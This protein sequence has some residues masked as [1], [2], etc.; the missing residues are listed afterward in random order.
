[1]SS[2][3][4]VND[5]VNVTASQIMGLKLVNVNVQTGFIGFDKRQHDLRSRHAAEPHTD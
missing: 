4:S 5:A 3:Q 2:D 1:M